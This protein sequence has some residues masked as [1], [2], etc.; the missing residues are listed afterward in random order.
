MRITVSDDGRTVIFRLAPFQVPLAF[1]SKLEVPVEAIKRAEATPRSEVPHGPI[2]RAPGAYIPGLARFGS[3]GRKPNRHF[4]AVARHDPVLVVD[5]EGWEYARI[6][7][8][9]ADA[10]HDAGLIQMAMT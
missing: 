1:K 3:Y 10:A 9:V 5:L 2:V 4:W 7:A 8:G 6:V